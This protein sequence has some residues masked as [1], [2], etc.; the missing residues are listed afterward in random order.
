MENFN[1]NQAKDGKDMKDVADA[2]KKIMALQSQIKEPTRNGMIN[3]LR[4][5]KFTAGVEIQQMEYSQGDTIPMFWDDF[6][7]QD[8]YRKLSQYQAGLRQHCIKKIGEKA[9]EELLKE[10]VK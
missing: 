10:V 2:V 4:D 7:D 5:A 9:L 8:L 6:S 1:I 3:A